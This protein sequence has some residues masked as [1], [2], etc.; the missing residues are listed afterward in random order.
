M[1]NAAMV[2]IGLSLMASVLIA[3]CAS[4]SEHAAKPPPESVKADHTAVFQKPLAD[5]QK[6]AVD[7]LVVI[8][9]DLKAQEPTY[10][11][12]H[13]PQKWGLFVGS[14]NETVKV[15]LQEVDTNTTK[16]T[17]KT[18]Q[19]FVGMAG[20]KNWHKEVL[21]EMTKSLNP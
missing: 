19:S 10:V 5:T 20:Q 12:G 3:G 15:W 14:G 1:R 17:V 6:A 16:V 4:S 11:E 21:D 9:C 13:R 18:V 7:A 8:G 2:R